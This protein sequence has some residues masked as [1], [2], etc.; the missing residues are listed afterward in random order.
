MVVLLAGANTEVKQSA[1]SEKAALPRL[2]GVRAVDSPTRLVP[3]LKMAE[4]R[5]TSQRGCSFVQRRRGTDLTEFENKALPLIYHKI[6]Q[7]GD[8][9]GITALDAR[10]NP[11]TP[12]NAP[13]TPA[14]R[15]FRRTP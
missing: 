1:T 15:I 2:A 9:L 10:V 8:N 3:A 6:G 12:P 11:E 5:G 13:S 7:R 14:S 4:R